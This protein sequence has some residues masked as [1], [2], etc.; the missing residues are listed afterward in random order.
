MKF[1]NKAHPNMKV[2]DSNGTYIYFVNGELE[3]EDKVII[4]KL[5][6]MGMEGIEKKE[7]KNELTYEKF[8]EKEKSKKKSKQ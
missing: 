4:E 3:T 1:I 5:K 2:K 8:I 7:E 6:A